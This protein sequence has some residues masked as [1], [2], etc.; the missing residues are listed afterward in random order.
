MIARGSVCP[1]CFQPF[2]ENGALASLPVGGRIATDEAR[3]RLW[4]VCS[5]CGEWSPAP[6]EPGSAARAEVAAAAQHRGADGGD[7][8]R[9][10]SPSLRVAR[11]GA[12]GWASY[13]DLRYSPLPE[14]RRSFPWRTVAWPGVFL[15]GAALFF[16]HPLAGLG[17]IGLG[18]MALRVRGAEQ[19][20][21]TERLNFAL[22]A[23]DGSRPEI[24][25]RISQVTVATSPGSPRGFRVGLRAGS[26]GEDSFHEQRWEMEDEDALVAL[27]FVLREA[28]RARS[29]DT[30]HVREAVRRVESAGGPGAFLASAERHVRDLR[31]GS[32]SVDRLPAA[33]RY[34]LEIAATELE[35]DF[36][37]AHPEVLAARWSRA[38]E[39]VSRGA[40]Y[41][42]PR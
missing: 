15:A 37:A 26:V 38:R 3:R 34:A 33:L 9:D 29:A 41:P 2:P 27:R 28:A 18:V 39:S 20:V 1:V 22:G 24:R 10:V 32:A 4:L 40:S 16:V 5:A 30:S 25:G 23:E 8:W 36:L 42:I 19:P 7:G 13:A 31:R 12:G 35:E 6:T 11:V 17:V 14:H 21:A